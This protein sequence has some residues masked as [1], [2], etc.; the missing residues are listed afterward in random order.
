MLCGTHDDPHHAD[1]VMAAAILQNVYYEELT[2]IRTRDP[3]RLDACELVFDVGGIYEPDELSFDHHQFR[4]PQDC[5]RPNGIPYAS[6]G[7]LWRH[8][9]HRLVD[10]IE[11]GQLVD[12]RLIQPVDAHDTGT[13][14]VT[15]P[16]P[17]YPGV[18]PVSLSYVISLLNRPWDIEI[19]TDHMFHQAVRIVSD[20]LLQT[21]Q[22]CKAE[23]KARDLVLGAELKDRVL[24]LD[25]GMPWQKTVVDQMPDVLLVVLPN[26]TGDWLV[27]TVPQ[28]FGSH[29]SR[30]KLPTSWAGLSDRALRQLT[31]VPDAVFCHN[32]LFIAGAR[33]RDGAERLARLAIN[34]WQLSPDRAVTS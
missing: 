27:Q 10:S 28:R 6:A 19:P 12:Q 23:L 34:Y 25:R 26:Q 32:R 14:L 30:I 16:T 4:T 29:D 2:I 21:I 20:I 13:Q 11:L 18:Q 33:S 31:D 15:D 7:M 24:Y 9:A 17:L 22:H 8:Y 3:A 5:A 1:D